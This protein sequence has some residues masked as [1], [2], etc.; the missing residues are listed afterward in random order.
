[1][2]KTAARGPYG[3]R[4]RE[5]RFCEEY[6]K[7]GNAGRAWI[8]AGHKPSKFARDSACRAL[9]RPA[10][11]QYIDDLR[12]QREGRDLADRDAIRRVVCQIAADASAAASDRLRAL[13]LLC[14]IDGIYQVRDSARAPGDLRIV[15]VPAGQA[16]SRPK[17]VESRVVGELPAVPARDQ[18]YTS[19]ACQSGQSSVAIDVPDTVDRPDSARTM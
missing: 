3:L 12:Q 17:A 9:R 18:P 16:E 13:D 11:R 7:D 2:S 1:M 6:V 15:V 10:I 5:K 19:A 8:A 14:R 4:Y